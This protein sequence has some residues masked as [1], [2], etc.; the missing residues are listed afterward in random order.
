MVDVHL[1]AELVMLVHWRHQHQKRFPT[2]VY[3]CYSWILARDPMKEVNT[4]AKLRGG[5]KF[6][7][8]L[9]CSLSTTI[10]SGLLNNLDTDTYEA[11]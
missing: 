4:E 2:R 11:L 9:I 7:L 10:C 6:D 1:M 3:Y 5:S 8:S